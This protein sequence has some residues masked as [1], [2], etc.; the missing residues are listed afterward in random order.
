MLGYHTSDQ[1]FTAPDI[2]RSQRA[3]DRCLRFID[4]K[5]LNNG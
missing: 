1:R 2:T 5:T 3:I 4:H